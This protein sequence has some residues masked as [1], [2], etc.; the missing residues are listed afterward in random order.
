[1]W[2]FYFSTQNIPMRENKV[3]KLRLRGKEKDTNKILFSFPS[4]YK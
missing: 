1:M 4:N 2:K 3:E